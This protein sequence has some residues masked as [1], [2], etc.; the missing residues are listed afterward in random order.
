M[1][2]NYTGTEGTAAAEAGMAV[3]DGS[4]DRR[5]GWL[6]INKTRDYIVSRIAA[7]WPLTVARGGTGASTPALART[8][9]EAVGTDQ[10]APANAAQAN[11]VPT[12]NASAQLTT[13]N[14]TLNG[15]AASKQYVDNRID[16]IPTPPASTVADTVTSAAYNRNATGS[17]FVAMWMNSALQIMRNTSS[18]R[19]KQNIRDWSG[20]V[21][22]LRTVIFD[23]RGEDAEVDEV[24]FIAEEVHEALPEG[25]FWFDGE[26]DGINDRVILA[27]AV[28]T[29]QDL[30]RRI[31]ELEGRS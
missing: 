14:P 27:A 20:S 12:Y 16:S 30:H 22:D 17:G 4:E 1:P 21:L 26:I 11:K 5:Q 23:R 6:A 15:H 19:Y 24:G 7:L 28:A 18:R 10:L 9:L 13:A 31:V 8:N 29:I 3:L 25:A 2:E